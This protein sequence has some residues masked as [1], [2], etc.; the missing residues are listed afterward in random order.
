MDLLAAQRTD[1]MRSATPGNGR[2]ERTTARRV[3]SN[4]C[5]RSEPGPR[6]SSTESQL[7]ELQRLVGN[8]AVSRLLTSDR[9]DRP[10]SLVQLVVQRQADVTKVPRG[11][12]CPVSTSPP[13]E[14]GTAV[15]FA[16]GGASVGPELEAVIRGF[17]KVWDSVR[18][19]RPG[20]VGDELIVDGYGSTIGTQKRNWQLSCQRAEAVRAVLSAM[21]VPSSSIHVFA[22]GETNVFDPAPLRNQRAVISPVNPAGYRGTV[23]RPSS[24][25]FPGLGVRKQALTTSG[26]TLLDMAVA[27]L[28]TEHM[29]ASDYPLGDGKIEDAANFGI[30]KQN[31]HYIRTSGAMPEI[32]S[33]I[34]SGL[35]LSKADWMRG[36]AL[37][38]DLALDVRVL[39]ASQAKLGLGQWFA[40]HRW[41]ETG[42]LAFQAA[43]NGPTTAAQRAT[44]SDIAN[45]QNA[46]EWIRDQLTVDPA[47]QTDDRKVF[48]QVPAV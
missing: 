38:T 34:M 7:L 48:V 20:Q 47:L 23:S 26:G 29:D 43:A 46:V 36:V 32:P 37:N 39:H 14:V 35:G 15:I 6:R 5:Q 11:L 2:V 25:T 8:A 33:P 19:T 13:P 42:Q 17:V 10:R 31:W 45:Y 4:W 40:A 12:S 1:R 21:G 22:H 30:F 3:S 24:G 28:E 27:M 41:G 9:A 18:L 44:L 16:T